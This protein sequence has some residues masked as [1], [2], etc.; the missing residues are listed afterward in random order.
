VTST[1]QTFQAN[2][3]TL[4]VVCP[5]GIAVLGGGGL[6]GSNQNIEGSYPV[7]GATTGTTAGTTPTNGQTPNG[8]TVVFSNSNANNRV[9]VVCG[10]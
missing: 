3:A 7:T 5:A 8:W 9:F 1:V 10:P 4:T 2:S 6:R